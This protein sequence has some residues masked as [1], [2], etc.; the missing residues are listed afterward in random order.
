[1]ILGEERDLDESGQP[2]SRA[3][4]DDVFRRALTRRPAALALADAPNRRAFADSRPR[5]LTFAEADRAISAIAGR[6]RR[7]GLA[8]D[9]TVAIQLPNTVDGIVTLLGVLRAGMIPMPIPLLWRRA[10]AVAAL[11]RVGAKVLIT[12]GRVGD[13]DYSDIAMHLAAE[14][15]PIRY[16]CGFGEA[17][18]DGIV[19]FDDLYA[20]DDPVPALERP[21]N[22]AA[23]VAVITW[24]VTAEGLVPVAR[25]HGEL[26]AGGVAV[27][28]EAGIEQDAAIL[29]TLMPSSFAGLALTLVPWLL[30]GGTLALHHP[31]DP[32]AFAAQRHLL[33]CSTAVVPG[34]LVGRLADAGLLAPGD[35]LKT[36]LGLWRAPERLPNSP[37][38]RQPH[39]SLVDVHSFGE[40]GLVPARRGTTGK[41]TAVHFGTVSVP[42]ASAE[43][44]PIMEIARTLAGTVALR[45]PMIPRQPYPPDAERSDL[46]YFKT[47]AGGFAD[48]EYPCRV[49]GD[50]T[51]VVTGP[52]AGLV[53]VGGYRFPA[54]ELHQVVNNAGGR[55]ASLPDSLCG[56]RF[57]G[58]AENRD[59]LQEALTAAGVNALVVDAFREKRPD[60][61]AV[62]AA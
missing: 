15:F 24:D 12:S 35:G 34:P 26:L 4:L 56:Q 52:P 45:G 58:A 6:L 7:M 14:L 23:H 19:P 38:W 43:G 31:F 2:V 3:T 25:S 32:V 47:V 41:P 21:G 60:A 10:E 36:V 49:D 50:H 39:V 13:V 46:P 1:V 11:G 48:S 40:V 62:S 44:V 9:T 30:A 17:L 59:A 33:R 20:I 55:L 42:L 54:R 28:L 51:M 27:M 29:A 53:S 18:P 16:V 22:P 5:Q 8:T 37:A 61:A 57:A